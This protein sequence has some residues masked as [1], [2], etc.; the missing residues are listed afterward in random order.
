MDFIIFVD[1]FISARRPDIVVINKEA[2][3]IRLIDVA[4]PA[5]KCISAKG[6][7]H[8][9]STKKNLDPFRFS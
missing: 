8:T 5:D 1:H 9:K 7:F 2:A 3:T 4:V 6:S